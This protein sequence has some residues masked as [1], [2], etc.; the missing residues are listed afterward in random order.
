MLNKV[1]IY[2]LEE[3]NLNRLIYSNPDES[4]DTNLIYIKYNDEKLG[5][6]PAMIQIPELFMIDD[7]K[8]LQSKYT[9][10]E[11]LLTIVAKTFH[12]TTMVKNFFKSLDKKIVDDAT[13]YLNIWPFT[14]NEIKYKMIVRTVDNYMNRIYDNGII[15]LKF[16]RSKGFKTT[17]YTTNKECIKKMH[18]KDILSGGC[19]VKSIVELVAIWIKGCVFGLYLK[20]HQFRIAR[21]GIPIFS[22][23][24]YSFIDDSE[25]GEEAYDTEINKTEEN[26][27]FKPYTESDIIIANQNYQNNNEINENKNYSTTSSDELVLT[28]S[29]E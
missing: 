14:G 17:V 26:N 22:L 12:T 11:I 10:H 5:P 21:G 29:S 16:I 24:D 6:V 23:K 8:D 18:Y 13:N 4:S 15:K 20:P 2:K 28:S 9:T 1:K 7:I 25:S 27:Y 3:F 19:Y